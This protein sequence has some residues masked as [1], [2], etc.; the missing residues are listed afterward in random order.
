M[1]KVLYAHMSLLVFVHACDREKPREHILP[2]DQV[3]YT[4]SHYFAG[5]YGNH[6]NVI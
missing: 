4:K 6:H 3:F 1:Y 2:G 5:N